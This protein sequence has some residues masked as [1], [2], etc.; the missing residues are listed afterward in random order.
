MGMAVERFSLDNGWDFNLL[1]HQKQLLARQAEE[2][3]DEI[4]LA[5]ACKL[6]SKMQTLAC[7]TD[8][9][10][11]ALIASREHHHRRHLLFCKRVYMAQVEGARHV[12]LGTAQ[13]R[14]QLAEQ[15]L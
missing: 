13:A 6:W 14:P 4:L 3:P 12:H 10:R 7:R 2:M 8:A 11:E 1:E 5:P 9:Q 15:R